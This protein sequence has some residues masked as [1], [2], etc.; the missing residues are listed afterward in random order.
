M[1]IDFYQRVTEEVVE[2]ML[3][4]NV[5]PA[6]SGKDTMPFQSAP[7]A[8]LCPRANRRRFAGYILVPLSYLRR[9]DIV[10]LRSPRSV[11]FQG[12]ATGRVVV[13]LGCVRGI[14]GN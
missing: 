12:N 2:V 13:R 11:C 10:H 9:P 5:P 6:I 1:K 3:T 7:E 4:E 8:R 14:K